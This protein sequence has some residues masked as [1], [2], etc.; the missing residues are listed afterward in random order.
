MTA[1][2]RRVRRDRSERQAPNATT[3]VLL[4]RP[5]RPDADPSGLS[6]YADD[7]WQLDQ[8]IFE[9]SA[10][11]TRLN[12]TQIPAPLRHATKH[13]LWVLIKATMSIIKIPTP[14]DNRSI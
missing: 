4:R 5:V 8:G 3:L 11:T 2:A 6:R 14:I 13:Y 10:K 7:V 1:P 9:E 12:C